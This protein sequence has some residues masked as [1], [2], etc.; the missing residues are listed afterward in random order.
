MTDT[1]T[2]RAVAPAMERLAQRRAQRSEESRAQFE[3]LTK[4]IEQRV[5]LRQLRDAMGLTQSAA[6][7]IV[8][9]GVTQA[10][11]SRIESGEVSPRVDRMEL[12]LSSLTQHQ[13]ELRLAAAKEVALDRP[14]VTAQQAAEYLCAI[15]DDEDDAFTP[16]KL[17]KLL[18]YAQGKAIAAFGALLFRDPIVAWEHGPVV[19][20]VYQAYATHGRNLIPRPLGFDPESLD[21]VARAALEATYVDKGRF[22]AGALRDMTHTERPWAT[23]PEK[24]EIRLEVIR[25]FFVELHAAG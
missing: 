8:G 23:T 9:H 12:I 16:M 24:S 13:R 21:P 20:K 1:K 6:A 10:D 5:Q 19:V 14:L 15:R 3:T 11:I 17:Q 25:D 22:T 2:T 18:Y 7:R 4:R